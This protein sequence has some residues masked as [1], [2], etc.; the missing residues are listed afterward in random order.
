MWVMV[1]R[2]AHAVVEATVGLASRLVL[3]SSGDVYRA[4]ARNWATEPGPPEP[5]P[6]TEDAPLREKLYAARGETPRAADDPWR[7][8][9][10][11]EKIAV[12][13]VVMAE[14]R[15]RPT[16]LRL[17]GVYGPGDYQH[18]L[19]DYLKRMQDGRPAILLDEAMARWRFARGY[20]EN[21]AT[22]IAL[23]ATDDRAAGRTYNVAEPDA[24]TELEWVTRVA[25]AAGWHGRIVVTPADR[26]PIQNL[27]YD[28]SRI[29]RELGYLEHVPQDEALRRTVAWELAH[30]PE[31]LDP[32]RFDYDAE[33]AALAS[34]DDR[35]ADR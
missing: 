34:L 6:L 17:P 13:R 29:R 26:E 21:V 24:L 11:Y 31:T 3:V 4:F 28:S 33:D 23:A 22:A 9:D 19:F 5:V 14:P 7:W 8:L 30:P 32:K 16:V 25:E 1:E 12:E 18:R 2:Q 20:V 35:K 27:S 15:L 10:D